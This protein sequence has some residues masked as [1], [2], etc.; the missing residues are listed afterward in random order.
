MHDFFTEDSMLVKQQILLIDE[1]LITEDDLP[2]LYNLKEVVKNVLSKRDS[3]ANQADNNTLS[4]IFLKQAGSIF[5]K[6]GKFDKAIE[7]FTQ[8]KNKYFNSYQAM[9]I[10]KFIE[11]ASLLKNK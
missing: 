1:G 5:M 11:Q 2:P 6:E 10:D 3:L 9:D 8:I 7:A 4:P